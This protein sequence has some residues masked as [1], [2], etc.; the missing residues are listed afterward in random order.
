[1]RANIVDKK[2]RRTTTVPVVTMEEIPILTESESIALREAL[3]VAEARVKVGKG[4]NYNPKTFK[5]RLL[6]I[7]RNSKR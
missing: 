6:N 7:Y 1:M 4:V 3:S 2:R 5:N